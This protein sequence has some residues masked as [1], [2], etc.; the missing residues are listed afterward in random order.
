MLPDTM[1]RIAVA[2][3]PK[4]IQSGLHTRPPD[5]LCKNKFH[6]ARNA[7]TAA[8]AIMRSTSEAS[9]TD[10]IIVPLPD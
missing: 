8:T 10:S 1:K 6:A 7:T 5:R 9:E 4:A 2:V 3:V